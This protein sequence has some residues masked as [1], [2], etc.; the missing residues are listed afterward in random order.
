[1]KVSELIKILD[2][3]VFGGAAGC[4]QEITGGYTSDLLSDVIGHA[5]EGNI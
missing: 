4:D 3:K 5:E 2:L 1:M